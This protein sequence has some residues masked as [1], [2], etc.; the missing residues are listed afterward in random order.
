MI[1]L[2]TFILSRVSDLMRFRDGSHK[3]TAS[4]FGEISEKVRRRPWQWLDEHSRKEAWG[5]TRVFEWHAR[6]RAD[7]KGEIC[8]E[9]GQEHAHIF[10]L[11]SKGFFAKNPSSQAKQS[12]PHTTVMFYGNCVKMCEDFAPNFGDKRTGCCIR[13]THHLTLLFYQGIF[14]QK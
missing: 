11:T 2:R 5:C 3:G 14:Y 13:A 1:F 9:Q 7:R 6:F 12:I 10:S 8:E 4:D